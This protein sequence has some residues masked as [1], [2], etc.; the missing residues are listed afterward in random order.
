M[1]D[2]PKAPPKAQSNGCGCCGTSP[3]E[4]PNA[5]GCSGGDTVLTLEEQHILG[6]IRAIQQEA[7]QLK[8]AIRKLES[9]DARHP[10][11]TMLRQSLEALRTER[12]VL[13]E[14]RILAARE[15]MR[16]LGHEPA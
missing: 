15:R 12:E 1:P 16:I 6:R 10:D 14:R 3:R 8:E 5:L 7:Q 9:A 13:E 2:E 4:E 11:L